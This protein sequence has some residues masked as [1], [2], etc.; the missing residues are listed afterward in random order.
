MQPLRVA[1]GD[2]GDFSKMNKLTPLLLALGLCFA[3]SRKLP[4]VYQSLPMLTA[5]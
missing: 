4:P 3:G 1:A 2:A 5:V